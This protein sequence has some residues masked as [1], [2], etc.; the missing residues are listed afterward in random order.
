VAYPLRPPEHKVSL[1]SATALG[2]SLALL[3]GDTGM[4]R[5]ESHYRALGRELIKRLDALDVGVVG[6]RVA[7]ERAPH[8]Y[9]V[10]LLDPRWASHFKDEF[11]YVTPYRRGVRVS[12][13]F[14]S[15]VQDDRL[16]QHKIVIR[17]YC[18]EE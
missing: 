12:F 15:S 16:V 13:G 14:Y 1:V 5:M 8:I 10:E 7:S 9:I 2:A 17:F 18:A 3:D 6:S 11:V 4:K